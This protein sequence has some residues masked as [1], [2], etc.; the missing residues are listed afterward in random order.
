MCR[1]LSQMKTHCQNLSNKVVLT[2]SE[3]VSQVHETKQG[4][5]SSPPSFAKQICMSTDFTGHVILNWHF[6]GADD[7]EILTATI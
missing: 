3:I 1:S 6:A 7:E 4:T 5:P 2:V